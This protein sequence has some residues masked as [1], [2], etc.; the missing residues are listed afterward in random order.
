MTSYWKRTSKVQMTTSVIQD[1]T[2]FE[3]KSNRRHMFPQYI[4]YAYQN[5]KMSEDLQFL[6]IYCSLAIGL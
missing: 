2:Q 3:T 6:Q 1:I 4:L 5:I